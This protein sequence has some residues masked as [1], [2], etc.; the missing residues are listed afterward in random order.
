[1]KQR[2]S[3]ESPESAPQDPRALI[4]AKAFRS[5]HDPN[6]LAFKCRVTQ[7]ILAVDDGTGIVEVVK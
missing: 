2:F 4:G 3:G 5:A 1:M 7:E 6:K